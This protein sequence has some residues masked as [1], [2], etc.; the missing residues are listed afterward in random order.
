MERVR[1]EMIF[2]LTRILI[3][4]GLTVG[5]FGSIALL[6]SWFDDLKYENQVELVIEHPNEGKVS[7]CKERRGRNDWTCRTLPIDNSRRTE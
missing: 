1:A 7:Y 6:L 5:G 3:V 2:W 4:L